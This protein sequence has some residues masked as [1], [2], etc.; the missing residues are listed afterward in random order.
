MTTRTI[1]HDYEISDEFWKKVEPLLPPPKP[2]KKSGRPRKEDRKIMNAIFYILRTGC[3]WKALPRSYGAS[4]TVHDRFQEW[5]RAGLFEKMWEAGLL[6]YDIKKG[7]E[8]EWQAI[9][10]AMTKAPL[11]GVG[12]GPN[13]TDRD[14]K[15]TK[16]SMLTDGKGIP[17]SVAI[18]GANRHDK[19][20]VKGTLDAVIIERPSPD[21]VVQNMCMDKGYDFPD[22]RELVEEYGYTAHIRSR[23][24]ENIEKKRYQITGQEGGL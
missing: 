21:D 13:P 4:S 15:G 11:G 6:E 12:T 17:L 9:D 19:K 2:K 24:E 7:L 16:R 20:L 22:I 8:W 5:Q 3:Q 1:G 23:G 10:G 18:D 14:K